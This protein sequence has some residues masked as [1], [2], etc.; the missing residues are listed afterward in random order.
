MQVTRNINKED[1]EIT[2]LHAMKIEDYRSKDCLM[3][4]ETE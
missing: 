1:W 2:V 4:A 3:G